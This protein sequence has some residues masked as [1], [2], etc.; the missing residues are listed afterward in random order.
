MSLKS[1]RENIL[2]ASFLLFVSV[3]LPESMRLTGLVL[4]G[5]FWIYRVS[6]KDVWI[7]VLLC[8]LA[9]IPLYSY[10]EP[11]CTEAM[12]TEVHR[13]YSVISQG[14]NRM[15]VYS[16]T[17]LPYDAVIELNGSFTK[18]EQQHSFFGFDFASYL[19]QRGIAYEYETDS[20]HY[21]DQKKTLRHSVQSRIE[22]IEDP[23]VKAFLYQ[24]I[25]S[26]GD[27]EML[28]GS[29]LI[30]SGFS[31]AAY[32]R[33]FDGLLSFFLDD[34]K[35]RKA[36]ICLN[37]FLIFFYG[38]RMILVSS[39][40]YR[41]LSMREMEKEER[42]GFWMIFCMILFHQEVLSAGFLI[43]AVY[44]ISSFQKK[45]KRFWFRQFAMSALSSLLFHAWQPLH[46]LFFP[47]I[48]TCSGLLAVYAL[49][50]LVVPSAASVPI[51]HII[52]SFSLITDAFSIKGSMIGLGLPLFLILLYPLYR[53][54]HFEKKACALL[55]FFL[56]SGLF[57]PFAEVCFINVGQ[58][59]SILIRQPFNLCNIVIDTG[60]PNR[61]S[62]VQSALDARSVYIV[63]TMFITHMDSDH[64]GNMEA[65][66][67]DYHVRHVIT[68]HQ[69]TTYC[70][71]ME[72]HDLNSI[73]E[74]DENRSSIVLWFQMNR[75]SFL[76]MGDA[77]QTAEEKIIGKYGNLKCDILKLSHHGSAT[78][79]C[80]RFLDAVR[81]DIGIVSS[82]AYSIYHHPSP[83]T[84]QRMLKRHI[85]Y[86][87]TK[88][89]GDISIVMIG[90][91]RVLIASD[92]TI[93]LV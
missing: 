19:L 47:Y 74:E 84:V 82:G 15:L 49:L 68:E 17:P 90:P 6:V 16:Q 34:K 89:A 43:P 61:Y 46:S 60:K 53:F 65:V 56:L 9:W 29:F 44:R 25:F 52:N 51:I 81:P 91:L 1:F 30:R 31:F 28:T 77:D 21:T 92:G 48:L 35:R 3:L 24:M 50:I 14:R 83:E 38:W 33:L 13:S 45:E 32:M 66:K 72:F 5:F 37:L 20:I 87:D 71:M 93:A 23:E 36:G 18:I 78:G 10:E 54:E 85:P 42:C 76:M 27:E 86:L 57:H 55:W 73:K 22:S 88:T 12:V 69:G 7:I 67:K 63:D 4:I 11:E 2:L 40:I 80:D 75:L 79:S 64:S 26:C 8:I 41:L 62:S 70:G 59:D 58:G 39:L